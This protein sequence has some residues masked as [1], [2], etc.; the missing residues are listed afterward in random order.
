LPRVALNIE[1]QITREFKTFNIPSKVEPGAKLARIKGSVAQREKVADN[2]SKQFSTMVKDT[3][4]F[5]KDIGVTPLITIREVLGFIEK[6]T[7]NLAFVIKSAKKGCVQPL[8]NPSIGSVKGYKLELPFDRNSVASVIYS[9]DFERL[10]TL[11]HEMRHFFDFITQPKYMARFSPSKKNAIRRTDEWNFFEKGL[12]PPRAENPL[13]L[14]TNELIKM[15]LHENKSAR[16]YAVKHSIQDFFQEQG[17]SSSDQIDMLQTW[18]HRLKCEVYACHEGYTRGTS[19][20]NSFHDDVLSIVNG[21]EVAF[22][23]NGLVDTVIC[24]DTRN[25]STQKQKIL[26]VKKAYQALGEYRFETVVNQLYFFPQKIKV[27]EEML[28]AEIA[29]VRAKQKEMF[30]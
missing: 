4:K 18:R 19:R 15:R 3:F 11:D 21:E 17:A 2:L 25:H 30:G 13:G 1:K 5:R 7:P 26:E 20:A 14:E 12:Y 27:I 8:Y 23:Y 22:Q 6:L 28:A 24:T 9:N 16:S 10:D 29:K